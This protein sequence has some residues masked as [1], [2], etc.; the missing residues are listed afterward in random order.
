MQ[1][2]HSRQNTHP[3]ESAPAKKLDETSLRNKIPGF[4]LATSRMFSD[5]YHSSYDLRVIYTQNTSAPYGSTE[6]LRG[7]GFSGLYQ[8]FLKIDIWSDSYQKL[9]NK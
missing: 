9:F 5:R 3:T 7:R 8:H 6:S 1:D 4:K 2:I